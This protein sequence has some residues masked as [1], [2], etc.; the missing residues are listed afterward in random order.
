M[1]GVSQQL[2][3]KREKQDFMSINYPPT[4]L[5]SPTKPSLSK[6]LIQP[7]PWK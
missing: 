1:T 3:K 5:I 4:S 7:L 2:K 6:T